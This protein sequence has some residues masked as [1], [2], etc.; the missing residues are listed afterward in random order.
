MGREVDLGAEAIG[1]EA[2]GVFSSPVFEVNSK[3]ERA[4]FR[5]SGLRVL[6]LVL[7]LRN[8]KHRADFFILF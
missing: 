3:T 1:V 7:E 2:P 6:V 8:S 5:G 4:S